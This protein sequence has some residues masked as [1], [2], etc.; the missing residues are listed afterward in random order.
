MKR[1]RCAVIGAGW[2]GTTAH[3]PALK[4]HP[5]ADLVAVQHHDPATA[6]KIAKDFAVR[7]GRNCWRCRTWMQWW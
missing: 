6:A 3:V 2:W 5:D 1:V 4:K 7:H